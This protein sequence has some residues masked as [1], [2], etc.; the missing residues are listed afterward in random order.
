MRFT[1]KRIDVFAKQRR[2]VAQGFVTNLVSVSP[3]LAD[4]LADLNHV[5]G[6]DGVVQ[7]RQTI[8][9]VYLVAKFASS[10]TPSFSK[11]RNRERSCDA[12]PLFTPHPMGDGSLHHPVSSKCELSFARAQFPKGPDRRCSREH[13]SRAAEAP[14]TAKRFITLG[15]RNRL[16]ATV[17]QMNISGTSRMRT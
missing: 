8:E 6:N 14:V 15:Q 3:Q 7:N 16:V 9:C 13:R 17:L 2:D 5:P 12:S 1:S 10:Q 4:N 11:H